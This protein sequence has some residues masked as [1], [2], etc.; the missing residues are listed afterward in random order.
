MAGRSNWF[1]PTG[2]GNWRKSRRQWAIEKKV[3]GLFAIYE[4]DLVK[5]EIAER[6][7]LDPDGWDRKNREASIEEGITEA[8]FEDRMAKSTV[9]Y[10]NKREAGEKNP[11]R[12]AVSN[13]SFSTALELLKNGKL[14]ARKSWP[15][16]HFLEFK[17]F[18]RDV[19]IEKTEGGR[20]GPWLCSQTDMLAEDWQVV[21]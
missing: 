20:I 6:V 10:I 15:N 13:L 19:G 3:A 2:K 9:F 11:N 21:K 5:L 12:S 17:N 8:E 16:S 1:A 14:I 7:V 4:I 18:N